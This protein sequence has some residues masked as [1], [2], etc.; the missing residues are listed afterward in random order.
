M[1]KGRFPAFAG[2][3]L[4]IPRP[5]CI[6]LPFVLLKRFQTL[7]TAEMYIQHLLGLLLCIKWLFGNPW[8]VSHRFWKSFYLERTEP[9]HNAPI[10][11]HLTGKC[12]GSSKW[13]GLKL[14]A[15]SA[16]QLEGKVFLYGS[17]GKLVI[18][19]PSWFVRWRR[20]QNT[21]KQMEHCLSQ[22]LCSIL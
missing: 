3:C 17:V 8:R 13:S 7:C 22:E 21:R 11:T 15:A 10:G 16:A 20:K 5:G 12:S 14:I 6:V 1:T 18:S 4:H 2:F 19:S 9:K